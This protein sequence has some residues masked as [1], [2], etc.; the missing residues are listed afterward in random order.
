MPEHADTA[1]RPL[2]QMNVRLSETL[3]DAA[4]QTAA[5][6]ETSL[7]ALVRAGIRREIGEDE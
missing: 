4:R 5:E 2:I 1:D 3:L 6:R 7:S